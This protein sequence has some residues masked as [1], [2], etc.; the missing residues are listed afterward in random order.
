MSINTPS[1]RYLELEEERELS[2]ALMGGTKAMQAEA[3]DFMPKH[4]AEEEENYQVRLKSTTLYGAY[5]N[6][7]MKMAGKVFS[8]PVTINTDIPKQIVA[9][10]DNID[11]QGR[12]ITSF[13]FDVFV[14]GISDGISFIFVDY[15]AIKHTEDNDHI[16]TAL[17]VK[18]M[19]ARSTAILYDSSQVIDW[20][21]ENIGG[22]QTLTCVRIKECVR[23]D[24]IEDE[25]G[26]T[27][28]DQIRV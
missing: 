21:S 7:I 28:V 6:T 15:T 10:L 17:D 24:D 3:K 27:I 8:K 2:R 5:K 23:D 13:L 19:G 4:P 22:V 14:K 16:L 11:G 18:N 20:K 26:E 9:I 1:K 12:N 25:W